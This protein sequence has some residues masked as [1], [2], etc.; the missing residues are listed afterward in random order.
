MKKISCLLFQTSPVSGAN[1]PP[2]SPFFSDVLYGAQRRRFHPNDPNEELYAHLQQLD[3]QP[4]LQSYPAAPTC[5]G[6]PFVGH[7]SVT[8]NVLGLHSNF[9]SP[10]FSQTLA[11]GSFESGLGARHRRCSSPSSFLHMIR[12]DVSDC[13]SGDDLWPGVVG[14]LQFRKTSLGLDDS[15][16]VHGGDWS[17]KTS[18]TSGYSEMTDGGLRKLSTASDEERLSTYSNLSRKTSEA[19]EEEQEQVE[20]FFRCLDRA[21][22][23]KGRAAS[24]DEGVAM[25]GEDLPAPGPG[26]EGDADNGKLAKVDD[27]YPT[28]QLVIH[29]ADSEDSPTTGAAPPPPPPPE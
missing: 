28:F 26:A 5:T 12:E 2:C 18:S 8:S 16:P 15:S 9:L 4:L 1:Y 27:S 23:S 6:L 20:R 10:R 25:L 11:L 24:A 19:S 17:R 14:D 13:I 29:K 22:K 21:S 3:L 7:P